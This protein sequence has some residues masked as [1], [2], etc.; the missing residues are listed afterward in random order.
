MSQI[1]E[2]RLKKS[3]A[4]AKSKGIK[5]INCSR[6]FF[7]YYYPHEKMDANSRER[8]L[9]LQV[10]DKLNSMGVLREDGMVWRVF[11]NE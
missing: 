4:L 7:E 2:E 9:Y 5:V 6:F 3:I 1:L 10:F 8:F 11:L